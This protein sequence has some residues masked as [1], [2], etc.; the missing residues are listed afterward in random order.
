MSRFW[1]L[2]KV[3]LIS[4]LG[5]TSLKAQAGS[6]RKAF[7]KRLGLIALF[8]VAFAP[9]IWLY[10][11]LLR[12]GYDLLAPL[13]QQGAILTL[14]L[15]L[16]SVM[17]FFFGIFY[18]I[19]YF[20]FAGDV[21]SVL[22]LPLRGWQVLGARFCLVLCYEYLTELLFLLPPFLIYGIKS[23][24]GVFYWL[25][26]AVGFILMPLLPLSLAA[27]P[28]VIAMRFANL[29]RRKDLLRILGGLL[30]IG[31]AVGYQ[32]IFQKTGPD[33]MDPV[34]VQN[35]LSD[36][37]GF[38]NLISRIF[39]STRYIGL[40]L[41]NAGSLA[42][43]LSLLQFAGLS[44]LAVII[45]WLAGEK[46]YFPGLVGST[47]TSTRRKRLSNAEF[48]RLG[49]GRSA[50]WSYCFKEISLLLR[51]PTY[52]INCVM[53]NLLVPVLLLIPL[54]I[55]SQNTKQAMPWNTLL[56]KPQGQ[57]ILMAVVVGIVIFLASSTAI[58]ATSLSREGKEFYISKYLP[59]SYPQ[60]MWAKML[61]AYIFGIIGTVI[62]IAAVFFLVPFNAT[63]AVLLLVI[64][65]VAIA[66][67]IEAGLLIDIF[68]PKLQ[69]E[70]EQQAFKQNLNVI[71]S[72]LF[73]LLFGGVI[74][75]VVVRFIHALTMAAGFMLIA[76]GLAAVVLYYCL[77][78]WGVRHY[79]E[80]E[81]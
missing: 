15:V 47:E 10:V 1:A 51:T 48:R 67:V 2:L 20:Y 57:T 14:G 50:V 69:W 55:Q 4:N 8:V 31:L 30:V 74:V 25:T 45:L 26:A 9:T 11:R 16:M 76:F 68:R 60:Q 61:S 54:F 37:S 64:C 41:V 42:G 39:P 38:M 59:I 24:A 56:G 32:F 70:N 46:L 18:V 12:Q 35:L 17:I 78:T 13:G 73:A 77:M 43:L 81:G 36:R 53:T 3:L 65:L 5:I 44:F 19:N 7:F 29:S 22:A 75:F 21:Q 80:L 33:Y 6:D 40:A 71:F 23:G 49:K 63:L 79:Q 52:F 62:L 28:T 58:T 34:F 66:P 27:I 72:M